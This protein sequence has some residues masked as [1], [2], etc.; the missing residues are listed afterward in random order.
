MKKKVILLAWILS[1]VLCISFLSSCSEQQ[2]YNTVT[3]FTMSAKDVDEFIKRS[4][5]GMSFGKGFVVDNLYV[6]PSRLWIEKEFSQALSQFQRSL[7][8]SVWTAEE[9]DCDDFS[10]FAAFFAEYLHYNTQNKLPKTALCFGEFAYQRDIG[11]AHAINVFLYRENNKVQ[12]AF[13]EPQTCKVVVLS[14]SEKMSCLF[15]RF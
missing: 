11:G 2:S 5:I 8:T 10:R 7:K 9:N 15:Y 4:D 13:Y 6:L 3:N 1:Y 14:E 12:M